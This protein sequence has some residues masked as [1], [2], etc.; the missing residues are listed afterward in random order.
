MRARLAVIVLVGAALAPAALFGP[1]WVYHRNDPR[2]VLSVDSLDF[3]SVP[4]NMTGQQLFTIRNAGQTTVS[5]KK[6][7]GILHDFAVVCPRSLG[8]HRRM[9]D[10]GFTLG[11]AGDP[12]CLALKSGSSCAVAMAFQPRTAQTYRARFCFEFTST[13]ETW[14]QTTACLSV[15]G[16]GGKSAS[17]R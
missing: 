4:V 3:R 9:S 13:S 16:R 12:A 15:T 11:G 1:S 7:S 5:E 6:N 14:R 17:A 10:C 2:I 8:Q